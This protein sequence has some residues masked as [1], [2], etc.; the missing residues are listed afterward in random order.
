MAHDTYIASA[1]RQPTESGLEGRVKRSSKPPAASQSTILQE[2]HLRILMPL[3]AMTT[4]LCAL[5]LHTLK[6]P[7]LYF[8]AQRSR[9]L[10]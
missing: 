8:A 3:I 10:Q 5:S 1:S 9:E 7:D 2:K 6:G 4:Y